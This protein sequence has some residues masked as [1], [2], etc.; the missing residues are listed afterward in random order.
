MTKKNALTIGLFG[1]APDTTNMGVS[2][3]FSSTIEGMS[4]LLPDARFCV[5]D[6]G[7]GKRQV[8]YEFTETACIEVDQVGMRAGHRYY[9][10]ENITT[11][12]LAS[13]FNSYGRYLNSVVR[14]LDKCD[15][16]LDISGGDSFSDIYGVKRF[17]SVVRP[18][19]ITLRRQIP[20]ILLP[21]TYGPYNS[22]KLRRLAVKAAK[23]ADMAWARDPHSYEILRGMLGDD[24]D[25]HK[26]RSGVDFAFALGMRS[27][28]D[29]LG[30][31]LNALLAQEK[32][33]SP[34]VGF[35]VSGLIYNDPA[36]AKSQYRFK[37]DYREVVQE[38]CNWLLASTNSTLVIIP[39]VMS[40][41]ESFESDSG[42]S[43][44]VAE[45]IAP[46][47]RD[48]FHISPN[49]L[50]QNQTKW[51]ISQMDWFCGTRMHSAIAA[52]STGVAAS[53]IAYSDKTKGVFDTCGQVE[54]VVDPR[55]LDTAETV[56][57]LKASF[58]RR[59]DIKNSLKKALPH[60]ED[61]VDHQMTAIAGRILSV[62]A[63]I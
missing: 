27:A 23:G 12:A 63:N 20:L 49:T 28:K 34:I 58:M 10:P 39:H 55:I 16:V 42:A 3:L 50:D 38:F 35:N 4:K 15:V 31:E 7:I 21:Q 26:H 33:G 47:F 32:N 52:L 9:L 6:N 54:E 43:E 2:A 11:I 8:S 13:R 46:E 53:A 1:A 29:L 25:E 30:P 56:E 48:R 19:L 45:K 22:P 14:E 59:E 24:F 36:A 44:M 18:K 41:S 60:L 17:L 62:T 61:Q 51:L 57:R 37:A 40:T 5:F